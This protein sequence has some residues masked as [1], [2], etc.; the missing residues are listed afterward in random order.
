[1]FRVILVDEVNGNQYSRF[2]SDDLFTCEVELDHRK[3]DAPK[4]CHYEIMSDKSEEIESEILDL[5]VLA[6]M[7]S[8][9]NIR[10]EVSDMIN[11]ISK[12]C[13]DEEITEDENN[14]LVDMLIPCFM[15]EEKK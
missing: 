15:Q 8:E 10:S 9:E 4:G 11:K 7:V 13:I 1:M 12:A 5:Y 2:E 6:E 14:K 3:Y